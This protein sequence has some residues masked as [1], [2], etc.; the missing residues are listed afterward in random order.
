MLTPQEV[1]TLG[2]ALLN[3]IM[4]RGLGAISKKDYDLLLFHHLTEGA[5]LIKDG[6]YDLANKLKITEAKVKALR[7]ESS[8]RHRQTNHKAVL[9]QIVQRIID[10][11]SKPDFS[12]REVVVTLENPVERREFEHAVKRAQHN[13]EY[14]INREILR[15]SPIAL[16][17][18]ILANVENAE[19][20]FKEIVQQCITTKSRQQEI[21]SKSLTL[22][23][24][25]N[26]L[27]EDVSANNGAVAIL[28]AAA[29]LLCV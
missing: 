24:K 8:I 7:L 28:S 4:E 15:I 3:L 14:G 25:M 23:Q 1:Q 9:G 27:G 6:N 12:G 22:R 19:A 5:A 29:G 10:A 17:E 20:R 13:V 26:K 18:I 2:Q 11:A 16:F 21:L